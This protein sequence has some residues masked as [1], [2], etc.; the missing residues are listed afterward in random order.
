M[1]KAAASR[2]SESDAT[3]SDCIL[4]GEV[5][6]RVC[7]FNFCVEKASSQVAFDEGS[8]LI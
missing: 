1:E 5:A 8:V 6:T 2:S 4:G 7:L 3:F